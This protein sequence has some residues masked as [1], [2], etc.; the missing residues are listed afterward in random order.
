MIQFIQSLFGNL[1]SGQLAGIAILIP[2]AAYII[3]LHWDE[4]RKLRAMTPEERKK[5]FEDF[6]NDWEK[7]VW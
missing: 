1:S 3:Y 4:R 7:D 6:E 5:Y 2:M